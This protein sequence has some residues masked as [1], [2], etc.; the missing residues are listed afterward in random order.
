MTNRIK[1]FQFQSKNEL[2]VE[3]VDLQNLVRTAPNLLLAPHRTDFYHVFLFEKC[4]PLHQVDFEPLQIQ[5]NSLLFLDK[6]RVHQFDVRLNYEGKILIFTDEFY[7]IYPQ[8]SSFLKS[9]NLFNDL[10]GQYHFPVGDQI[11]FFLNLCQTIQEELLWEQDELKRELIK[12]QVHNFLLFAQR[13]KRKQGL[14]G[15]RK[16]A[17]LDYVLQFKDLL[18]L[19]FKQIKS[20]SAYAEK[21]FITEKRLNQATNKLLGKTPKQFIDERILLEAKRMLLH[22]SENVKA[23]AF[24]LGFEEPT[25]FN[26]Y[27]RKHTGKT[28]AEFRMQIQS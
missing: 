3:V 15:V 4:Q 1:K 20:V 11:A 2:Q 19:H 17:D 12:N 14:Q 23:I 22:E 6:E 25:N 8:D 18:E 7:C 26:K 28:P 9:S 5:E 16:S 27:F 21:L 24:N 10:F 13:E